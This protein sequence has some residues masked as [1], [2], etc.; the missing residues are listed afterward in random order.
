MAYKPF[1]VEA[2]LDAAAGVLHLK[3]VPEYREGIK[4]NL[5]TAAKMAALVEQVKLDDDMEPAPVYRT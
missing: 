3:V 2:L 5:K 1:D 4:N